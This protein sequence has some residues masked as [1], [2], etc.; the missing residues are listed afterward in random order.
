MPVRWRG[1]A[2]VTGIALAA[3]LLALLLLGGDANAPAPA[4]TAAA[5]SLA[6]D[7]AGVAVAAAPAAPPP[8]VADDTAS[9]P[10][11]AAAKAPPAAAAQ[12]IGMLLDRDGAPLR[13]ARLVL[14]RVDRDDLLADC[15]DVPVRFDLA[16]PPGP[17]R[18]WAG[19]AAHLWQQV[20]ELQLRS[21]A[22]HDLGTIALTAASAVT[23]VVDDERGQPV[24]GAS[25]RVGSDDGFAFAAA[26]T[27]ARGQAVL[28]GVADA[29]SFSVSA[30][31][32]WPAHGVVDR[33]A[34]VQHCRLR[35][36]PQL[37]GRVFGSDDAPLVGARVMLLAAVPGRRAA[38]PALPADA[39]V[40]H[41]GAD[42][43]FALPF[44]SAAA[45][46]LIA[47]AAGHAPAVLPALRPAAIEAPVLLRLGREARL[48]GRVLWTDG[49]PLAFAIVELWTPGEAAPALGPVTAPSGGELL[50]SMRSD[51]DGAFAAAALPDG[52]AMVRLQPSLGTAAAPVLL[53]AGAEVEVEL[54]APP[55]G[56]VSGR[57]AAG[58]LVF[59]YGGAALLRTATAAAD[60]SFAFTDVPA[61]QYLLGIGRAPLAAHLHAVAQQFTLD[62]YSILAAS[63][64]I[65]DGELLHADPPAA[66]SGLGSLDGI[67]SVAGQPV[68]GHDVELRPVDGRGAR[69]RLA[70]TDAAGA[71]RLED[72]LPGDYEVAL[73]R[74]GAAAVLLSLPCRIRAGA[75][76]TIDLRAP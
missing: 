44:A 28:D 69:R 34:A 11:V 61:G 30:A 5:P 58:A 75:A 31:G 17:C 40:M 36:A 43:S 68:A 21:G 14:L 24:Q 74:P 32:Y 64:H 22:V 29:A 9:A 56:G 48:R 62:G 46:D 60:G 67:A 16:V 38:P 54:R 6:A 65:G 57:A 15:A 63:I 59:L 25:V 7:A 10:T 19:A 41:T 1:A 4:A 73:R 45:C 13:A 23:L 27:D 37:R 66:V 71:F 42:G 12:L 39:A 76:A 49:R 35:A 26:R 70:R 51:A 47:D 20:G 50:A 53:T 2:V 18:I 33:R 55:N 72:L 3:V 8:A 52:A